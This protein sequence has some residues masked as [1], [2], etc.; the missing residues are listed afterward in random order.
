MNAFRIRACAGASSRRENTICLAAPQERMQ[1]TEAVGVAD[2]L[3]Q[4]LRL[5]DEM[6]HV[7]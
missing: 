2:S 5:I 1:R 3:A 6:S 7:L 4:P